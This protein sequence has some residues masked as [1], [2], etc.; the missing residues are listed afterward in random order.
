MVTG[1]YRQVTR[2]ACYG[3]LSKPTRRCKHDKRPHSGPG[4]GGCSVSSVDWPGILIG[5][6][7]TFLVSLIFYVPAARSLKR[8][9]ARL[10]RHTTMILRGL[11]EGGLIEL[12]RNEQGEIEALVIKAS[13]SMRISTGMSADA[14]VVRDA[15]EEPTEQE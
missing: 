7:I 15:D 2:F 8:E 1:Y 6:A 4:G 9:T 3:I 10:Q 13:A 5:G 12:S 14:T 11:E